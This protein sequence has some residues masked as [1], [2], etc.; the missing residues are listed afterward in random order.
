MSW[1][2]AAQLRSAAL[3]FWVVEA[4]LVALKTAAAEFH[5]AKKTA[6]GTFFKRPVLELPC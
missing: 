2:Q 5:V 3:A 1:E 4:A 6:V